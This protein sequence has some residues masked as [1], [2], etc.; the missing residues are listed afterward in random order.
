[1]DSRSEGYASPHGLSIQLDKISR[2]FG[3][4][5]PEQHLGFRRRIL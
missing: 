3:P 2:P 4:A 5:V 1:M